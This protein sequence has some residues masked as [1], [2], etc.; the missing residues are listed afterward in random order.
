MP[1]NPSQ[2]AG[3]PQS[4]MAKSLYALVL[5]A[6]LLVRDAHARDDCYGPVVELKLTGDPAGNSKAATVLKY[7]V[8]AGFGANMSETI[9]S[10]R[11]VAAQPLDACGPLS[12]GPAAGARSSAGAVAP[13]PSREFEHDS[14]AG[15]ASEPCDGR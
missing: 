13:P 9:T 10:L 4:A 12:A 2:Q 15:A 14:C 5:L 11:I 6:A 3:E 1:G 8:L 7:G